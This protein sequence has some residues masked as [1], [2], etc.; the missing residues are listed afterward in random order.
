M[1]NQTRRDF[2]S[3]TGKVAIAG[4]TG[5]FATN[6]FTG[7]M[8]KSMFIHHVYFWLKNPSG[9]TDRQKLIEGL[10]KL[11]KVKTIKSFH[12]GKPADT[13]RDVIDTS[14]SISWMLIFDDKAAEESYQTDPIHL[15]FVETCKDLW[16]KVVVYDSVDI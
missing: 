16:Q 15:N 12:I 4:S 7:T 9:E 2:I 10:Q 6:N 14:Y 1:S 11:S 8:A 5:I 3:N 13:N